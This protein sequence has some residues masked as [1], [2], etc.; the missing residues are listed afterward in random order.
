MEHLPLILSVAAILLTA[1]MAYQFASAA[2]LWR[3]AEDEFRREIR[4]LQQ[5]N[6]RLH[7]MTAAHEKRL[8]AHNETL[9]NFQQAIGPIWTTGIGRMIRMADMT[10]C[11][12]RN[13]IAWCDEN[14][15]DAS[16]LRDELKLRRYNKRMESKQ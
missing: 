1:F 5:D 6:E 10:D 14:C 2:I 4:Y 11:H 15:K 9:Y 7:R 16:D 8:N 13:A 12:L 3:T